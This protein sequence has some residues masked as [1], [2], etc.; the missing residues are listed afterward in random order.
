[1]GT[2]TLHE[3]LDQSKSWGSLLTRAQDVH[4]FIQTNE[5]VCSAEDFFFIGC[6]TSY[7]LALSAASLFQRITQKRARA[8][9]SSDVILFPDSVFRHNSASGLNIII[10]RSGTTT[11]A[12][13]AAKKIKSLMHF[14]TCAVSCRPE[15]TL[16]QECDY[17]LTT[18]EADEK[19]V[20]MTR[21]FT[22]MLLLLQLVA[23][24]VSKDKA[25]EKDL[26]KLPEIGEMILKEYHS[27]IKDLAE[28]S[29]V[30]QY[31]FLGQGPYYGLACESMLKMKEM[32]L[33]VSEAYHTMEF[34]HGPMSMASEQMLITFLLSN[35]GRDEEIAVLKDMKDLGARTL[36]VCD[37][38]DKKIKG[39]ADYILEIQSGL[40]DH[41]RLVLYM[42]LMQLFGYYRAVQKGL[43][44]DNPKNL[45][46]VVKIG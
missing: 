32:S 19:S 37:R 35:Q 5:N 44:P 13:W 34:R 25:F 39:L 3:I 23:S 7:Y 17:S 29:E 6:G 20:V 8:V 26:T 2:E 14:L 27:Q 1:M 30:T 4:A 12:L 43:D 45:T 46:Q 33:S 41:A 40:S 11:E 24:Y 18:P 16:I 22:T 31:V 42:P 38:I 21:S 15:S 28:N 36:V 9:T 10:S